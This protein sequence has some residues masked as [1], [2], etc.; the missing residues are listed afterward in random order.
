VCQRQGL[1]LLEACRLGQIGDRFGL[2]PVGQ[3]RAMFF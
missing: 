1:D 2:E 3:R